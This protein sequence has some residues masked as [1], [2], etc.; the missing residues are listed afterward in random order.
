MCLRTN[1][2]YVPVQHWLINFYNRHGEC[3]LRGTN[4]T[5]KYNLLGFV[6]KGLLQI[7]LLAGLIV[8]TKHN[9][10]TQEQINNRQINLHFY[11]FRTDH[12]V[13][14]GE[15]KYSCTLSLTSA[16]DG[17][18]W[19]TPHPDRFTPGK[20]TRYPLYRRLGGPQGRSGWVR[21]ISPHPGFDP[22]TVQ[23]VTSC[24][25]DYAIPAHEVELP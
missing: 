16:L 15:Q 6:L 24:Y 11:H 23:P 25:T 8:E 18:R 3:L 2:G 9:T 19:S 22:R 10:A 5:F 17:S 21:K 13:P 14:E 4:C 12:E 20:E 7:A 1:S